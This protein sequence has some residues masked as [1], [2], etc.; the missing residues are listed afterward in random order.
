MG[1]ASKQKK[2][3]VC[4]V[5]DVSHTSILYIVRKDRHN[6]EWQRCYIYSVFMLRAASTIL[7]IIASIDALPSA[8]RPHG[9]IIQ[10]DSM[11][12]R[13]EIAVEIIGEIGPSIIT[14]FLSQSDITRRAIY[15]FICSRVQQSQ[16]RPAV[17]RVQ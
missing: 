10:I 12:V 6:D 5:R 11:Y 15:R 13:P 9:P 2:R 14:A 7:E 1:A 16:S 3:P 17:R 4:H 8:S